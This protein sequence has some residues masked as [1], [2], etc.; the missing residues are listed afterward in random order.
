MK[1]SELPI[2]DEVKDIIINEDK[3]ESLYPPQAS[4]VKNGIFER[5]NFLLAIPT[6]SGKTLM[7]EM[8]ALKHILEYG[9][10]AIYLSP[11]R[12]LASEKFDDFR[13]FKNLGIKIALT[14]GEFDSE[15][16]YLKNQDW[17]L[18]TNEKMDSLIRHS[19]EL[20]DQVTLVIVDE[21]HLITESK[22]GP[23][24][25]I[26][27]T[28]IMTL[29]PDIQILGLSATISNAFDIALWLNAKHTFSDWR[30][31]PLEEGI[32]RD[33]TINYVS[34]KKRIIERD[35]GYAPTNLGI[36]T[37][38]EGGQV[39]IFAN[40]RR[41]SVSISKKISKHVREFLD[42]KTIQ[43]LSEISTEL[44][45]DSSAE[46]KT[47]QEL[48]FL[49]ANG[50]SYHNAGLTYTQ[51]KLIENAFKDGLLKVIVSTPT[52]AAGINMPA[53][54]VVIT[55]VDRYT[56]ETGQIPIPVFEFAQMKGRAGRPKY[57]TKGEVI[58]IAK[59][60]RQEEFL[61]NRYLLGNSEP[62]SSKLH[63]EPAL[64][65][66]ILGLIATKEPIA[67]SFVDIEIFVSKTLF[68]YQKDTEIHLLRKR[69]SKVI[70][71]MIDNGFI[72]KMEHILEATILGK[73]ISQLYL[74]PLA[75][76]RLKDG[77]IY[78][79]NSED[80][81]LTE[82]SFLHLIS[83]TPEMRLLFIR[84]KERDGVE[85]VLDDII[86]QLLL[87]TL[88]EPYSLTFDTLL[89]ELK[90]AKLIEEWINEEDALDITK[91][92]AI[93]RGDLNRIVEMAKWMAY[94]LKEI[95]RLLFREENSSKRASKLLKYIKMIE[96]RIAYGVRQDIVE[97][98]Q[99]K[100]LGRVKAR[101]L[102]KSGYSNIES[103]VKA[104]D[105]QLLQVKG[106]GKDLLSQIR[107]Q[108]GYKKGKTL[109]LE[110]TSTVDLKSNYGSKDFNAENKTE[111]SSKKSKDKKKDDN[112]LL[113]FFK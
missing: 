78:A 38:I 112:N 12:A 93:G 105:K 106:I 62:I 32:L 94:S 11:L 58:L 15:D 18:A 113:K 61:L 41:N 99:I 100:G 66:L 67:S 82:L 97:I 101:E 89:I 69:I 59:T 73:R 16:S 109:N 108:I 111:K 74:D 7:A 23:T 43:K 63:S 31:V 29:R 79:L 102:D 52:L 87:E 47:V 95:A 81:V 26:L 91:T 44:R 77:I 68:G 35:F 64:R 50:V 75:A 30:P 21:L 6:A 14:S 22:R 90:V 85:R 13:R 37:I 80:V 72:T 53:R 2:P 27:I 92:F 49:V 51:R 33:F 84:K 19:T 28:K 86:D 83:S 40:S 96:M 60:D 70:E 10:K 8:I 20:L 36:D 24:L 107:N 46:D 9:G 25:E 48:S 4:A 54:R 98:C 55:S 5:K 56:M 17:I 76:K 34:G 104:S 1:I 88:P 45:S 110:F 57:D 42:Q 71:F 103:I 3:I 39:L 65:G